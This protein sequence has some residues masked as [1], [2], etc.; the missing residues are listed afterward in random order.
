M[1]TLEHTPPV[2]G[3]VETAPEFTHSER[4][5]CYGRSV[6]T[7]NVKLVINNLEFQPM[8]CVP[9]KTCM[10]GGCDLRMRLQEELDYRCAIEGLCDYLRRQ[11]GGYDH[12]KSAWA[13]REIEWKCVGEAY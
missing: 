2:K 12:S 11:Y 7:T 13:R 5:A 6:N 1:R 4:H 8:P 10:S 3:K 9:G